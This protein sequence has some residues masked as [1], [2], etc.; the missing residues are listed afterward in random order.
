[1]CQ[2]VTVFC[3]TACELYTSESRPCP[4][5]SGSSSDLSAESTGQRAPVQPGSGTS[6]P[7]VSDQPYKF[8][9]ASRLPLSQPH[10]L[11]ASSSWQSNS[12]H[13][14]YGWGTSIVTG[15]DYQNSI[16]PEHFPATRP[17]LSPDLEW[18]VLDYAVRTSL[19]T[20]HVSTL[21]MR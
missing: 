8:S 20:I 15:R 13:R 6:H 7:Y 5:A 18:E 10:P 12:F 21:V 1:M 2:N 9:R 16:K 19:R 4:S 14:S 17:S 3:A 11:C